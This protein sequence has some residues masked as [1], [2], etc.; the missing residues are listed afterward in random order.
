MRTQNTKLN[1]K[2]DSI[3]ELNDSQISKIEGGS[4]TI[5]IESIIRI[6][7]Y[8]TWIDHGPF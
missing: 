2:K 6:K 1:F 3:V 7:T 8:G 4:L 5:V